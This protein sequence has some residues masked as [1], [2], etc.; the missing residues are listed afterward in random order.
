MFSP[1]ESNSRFESDYECI[2]V[3]MQCSFKYFEQCIIALKTPRRDCTNNNE[4]LH[5]KGVLQRYAMQLF[6]FRKKLV[7]A[8]SITV[9][10]KE[11]DNKPQ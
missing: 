8:I 3:V 1:Y 11:L 2:C 9:V 4:L 6:V 7:Q 10:L 5:K